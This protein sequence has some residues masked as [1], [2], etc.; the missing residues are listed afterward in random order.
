M[1]KLIIE[2]DI[3]IAIDWHQEWEKRKVRTGCCNEPEVE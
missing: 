2:A 1:V 3:A